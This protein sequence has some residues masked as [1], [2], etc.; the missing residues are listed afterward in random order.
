MQ[1]LE[2]PREP[3]PKIFERIGRA[4]ELQVMGTPP[5]KTRRRGAHRVTHGKHRATLGTHRAMQATRPRRGGRRRRR[6]STEVSR[7]EGKSKIVVGWI[8]HQRWRPAQNRAKRRR[9]RRHGRSM[10]GCKH[11]GTPREVAA[12]AQQGAAA[13]GGMT[14][15]GGARGYAE[16]SRATKGSAEVWGIPV[17]AGKEACPPP[18]MGD[19]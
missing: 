11:L 8:S 16:E 6:D 19:R 10:V 18:T 1:R 5:T 2:G 3:A 17:P 13:R 15:Q 12:G 9:S 7:S 14:G 4:S